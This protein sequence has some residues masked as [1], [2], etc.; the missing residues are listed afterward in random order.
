MLLLFVEMAT[1]SPR[2]EPSPTP[3]DARS[4]EHRRLLADG[5]ALM[6]GSM[7]LYYLPPQ[8]AFVAAEGRGA[9]LYD[10]DGRELLDFMMGYGPLILGHAPP[11]VVA[12]V[13]RRAA[14]GSHFYLL[15]REAIALAAE[16]AAA[17]LGA[18]RVR[19]VG[20]GSEA[21][22]AA[23]RL[24]RAFSGRS[25]V[26]VF[27]GSF[28]G[29]H[30]YVIGD[31]GG[32]PPAV[33]AEVIRA[34]FNDLERT[35]ELVAAHAAEL[36]AVVVE[37]IQRCIPPRPEL[38]PG[39]RALTREHD[40]LLIFDEIVTGFRLAYGGAQAHY[41]VQADLVCLGKILG[42]GYPLAAVAGRADV[43]SRCDIRRAGQPDY[44]PVSGTLSGNPLAAAAGLAT[45]A[46]LR[47]DGVYERLAALGDRLRAGLEE[48]G[49]RR[50][51]PLRAAG[52]AAMFAPIFSEVEPTDAATLAK[53]DH[54]L[55]Q[56]FG[57][58][59]IRRGVLLDRRVFVSTA[60]TDADVATALET[61]DHVI[62]TL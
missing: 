33:R 25:K 50:G 59:M 12:A 5:E 24:A 52:H 27:D 1:P 9:R 54:R 42:G 58:R 34:P 62:A 57:A 41:G 56:R 30:D 4:A 36:A 21:T 26:L 48:I 14:A 37:P 7:G 40:V 20:T 3:A 32:I 10:V 43:I 53:Q 13:Q 18:E 39:L 22:L 60:H 16:V 29:T 47:R 38:L 61:A 17:V 49:R 51:V 15:S 55:A 45:L 46:E 23:M 35:A 19:F 44:T 8:V 28:H 6:G 31:F 2:P 11:A